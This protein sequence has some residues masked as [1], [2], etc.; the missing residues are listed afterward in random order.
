MSFTVGEYGASK[1]LRVAGLIDMSSQTELTLTIYPPTGT[2][3]TKTTADGV[4]L[5]SGVTD[6]TLGVLAANE[7]VDYPMESGVLTEAGT[8]A[9]GDPWEVT[10]TYDNSG[11]SPPDH[12]IGICAQFDVLATCS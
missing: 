4:V 6:P 5:G 11:V 10:L 12:I 8:I 3:I 2:A 9:G 1:I 7:Y